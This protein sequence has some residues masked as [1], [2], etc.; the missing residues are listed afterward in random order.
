VANLNHQHRATVLAALEAGKHV[1][2][3]K[4]LGVNEY[5][6][7]QMV[8]KARRKGLFLMEVSEASNSIKF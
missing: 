6:V 5:E 1:L 3:E 4:P 8:D 2:C 7:R